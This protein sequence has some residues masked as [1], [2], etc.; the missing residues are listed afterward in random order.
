SFVCAG[1]AALIV[2]FMPLTSATADPEDA[3]WDARFHGRGVN[4]TVFAV[5]VDGSGNMYVGGGFSTAGSALASWIARW[6]GTTWSAVG[7]GL[8]GAVRALAADAAGNVY[9]GGDFTIA[10]A[11]SAS[12]VARWD[13][14]AW[15]ALGSG[16]VNTVYAL[17]VDGNGRVV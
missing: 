3:F 13:G 2:G 12:H 6:D 15:A 7:S 4:G 14:T 11:V 16:L 17:A 5:T 8:N 10:G 9:A 1:S